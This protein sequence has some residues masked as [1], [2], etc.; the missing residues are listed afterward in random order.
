MG[1][2]KGVDY[3]RSADSPSERKIGNEHKIEYYVSL[4]MAKELSSVDPRGV[5]CNGENCKPLTPAKS[6]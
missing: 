6:T 1:L 2:H 4:D 5:R 3:L